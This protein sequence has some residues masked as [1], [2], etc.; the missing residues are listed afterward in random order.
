MRTSYKSMS[1]YAGYFNLKVV[2]H[3]W[4]GN[5]V[6]YYYNYSVCSLDGRITYVSQKSL[7]QVKEYLFSLDTVLNIEGDSMV[8]RKLKIKQA[9]RLAV[10]QENENNEQRAVMY[11][12]YGAFWCT[13]SCVKSFIEN[14]DAVL[15]G[16]VSPSDKEN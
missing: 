5:R 7:K 10:S 3:Q 12:E 14:D 13:I 8:A 1:D 9:Y 4:L 11:D 15:V 2:K 16:I 6:D